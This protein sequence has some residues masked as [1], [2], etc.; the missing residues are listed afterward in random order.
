MREFRI[1]LA[2][3]QPSFREEAKAEL[4]RV[5]NFWVV[6]EAT[7]GVEMLRAVEI[8]NPNLLIVE[9]AI[10]GYRGVE[11]IREI[12][13]RNQKVKILVLTAEGSAKELQDAIYAGARGYLLKS[14]WKTALNPA[15]AEIRADGTFFDPALIEDLAPSFRE[16]WLPGEGEPRVRLTRRETEALKY[17][18]E[19][20]SNIEIGEKMEIS[21]RTAEKHR[22]NILKKLDTNRTTFLIKYG[23]RNGHINLYEGGPLPQ[24]IAAE[25][26]A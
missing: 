2:D 4:E 6:A 26:E 1:L 22:A 25:M 7:N 15:V 12:K 18:V 5:E 13:K 24:D 23:L 11:V 10:L 9:I 3:D 17:I 8:H 20:Y 14:N 19:G 16:I 21:V